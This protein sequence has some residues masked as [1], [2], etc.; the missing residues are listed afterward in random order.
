MGGT[1]NPHPDPPAELAPLLLALGRAGID[2]A[3]HP[4]DSGRLRFKCQGGPANLPPH[5]SARL[6]LH[7]GAV[8]G[9]LADGYAT[10]PHGDTDARYVL[11]ERLGIADDLGTPTHPGSPAWLLALGEALG[12][13]PEPSPAP[14]TPAPPPTP[15]AK[16]DPQ[17]AR[18]AVPVVR[19]GGTTGE[20]DIVPT[21]MYSPE[22]DA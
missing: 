5:L 15:S 3:P 14:L 6:R 17:E 18:A 7:R 19:R 9:L 21:D 16:P 1:V 20:V 22:A 8:L 13:V 10:D 4:T 11:G 2:L 12:G